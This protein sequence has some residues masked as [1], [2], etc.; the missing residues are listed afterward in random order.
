VVPFGA[1]HDRPDYPWA[2]G[3]ELRAYA[4][5]PGQRTRVRVPGPG[6]DGS[7]GAV[8][9]VAVG[10]DG[11]VTADLVEG[12]SDGHLVTVVGRTPDADGAPGQPARA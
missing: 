10:P 11:A 2:D 5:S 6:P 3:V 7:G 12:T 8:F 1:V 9:E 4:P